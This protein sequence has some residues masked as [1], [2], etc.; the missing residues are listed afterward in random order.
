MKGLAAWLAARPQNAVFGLVGAYILLPSPIFSGGALAALALRNDA[1]T[2]AQYAG[3]AAGILVLLAAILSSPV[4]AVVT[5]IVAAWVPVV[6]LVAL[7]VRFRSV[8]LVLQV[9]VIAAVVVTIGFYAV[10]GDPVPFWDGVLAGYAQA[11]RELGIPAWADFIEDRQAVIAK[12]MTMLFV[13]TQWTLY[14]LAL[15]LGYVLY[16]TYPD[17][18]AVFGRICDLNFGR[19]LASIM[20]IASVIA[21]LADWTWLQNVAFVMFAPFCL[22]G[23]AV[24]HWLKTD[25]GWPVIVVIAAYVMLLLFNMAMVVGLAVVGYTDAWFDYRTSMAGRETGPKDT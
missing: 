5:Q 13:F 4:A 22:Q 7:L 25:K 1:R 14:V 12:Q 15:L 21:L 19:V 16:Q 2:T 6:A 23:L 10:L 3:I 8:T 24:L 9:T 11:L 20:A 18:K 17:K